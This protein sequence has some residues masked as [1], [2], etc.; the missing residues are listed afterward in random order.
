MS[1]LWKFEKSSWIC[2]ENFEWKV[3]SFSCF[4]EKKQEK[5]RGRNRKNQKRMLFHFKKNE[6]ESQEKNVQLKNFFSL[7][8]EKRKNGLSDEQIELFLFQMNLKELEYFG[9]AEKVE[10]PIVKFHVH[11]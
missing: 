6:K 5:E 11:L 3:F 10:L 8:Q 1:K 4:F 9:F 2:K 7:S